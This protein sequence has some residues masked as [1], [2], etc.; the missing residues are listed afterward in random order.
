MIRLKRLLTESYIPGI[1]DTIIIA[2]TIIGE[3]GGE[4]SEGMH[5]IK[6]VLVNRARLKSTSP[7][8]E[9][10][11]PKQFS[12]WNSATSGINSRADYNKQRI[13]DVID[14]YT[15]HPKWDDAIRLANSNIKD[16]TR[17][18]NMYYASDGPN[19]INAPSW[20]RNWKET[21]TIG[22]HTF[23]IL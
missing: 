23:G 4:G 21:V 2:A 8:G 3:A 12:M 19:A 6:N 17:G 16:I 15:N 5:A 11:R 13:L 18:A 9:A 22:N 7:A 10:L 20:T 1:S 14:K